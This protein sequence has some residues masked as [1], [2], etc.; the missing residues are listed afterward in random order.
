IQRLGLRD[1][2]LPRSI[3][4]AGG[5]TQDTYK[6]EGSSKRPH[7]E[8]PAW[9]SS[10]DERFSVNQCWKASSLGHTVFLG[11]DARWKAERSASASSSLAC[12]VIEAPYVQLPELKTQQLLHGT[13]L[14]NGSHP[15]PYP[16][17]EY[18]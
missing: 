17:P 12:F 6:D 16:R 4:G 5:C 7:C 1:V 11:D 8:P 14:R 15:V 3:S 9:R 13:R 10:R 18:I 2:K